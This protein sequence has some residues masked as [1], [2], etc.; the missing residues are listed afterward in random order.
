MADRAAPSGPCACR[1]DCVVD[2]AGGTVGRGRAEHACRR[3]GREPESDNDSDP[4]HRARSD[5]DSDSNS[6]AAGRADID[7]NADSCA[8]DAYAGPADTDAGAANTDSSAA[9]PHAN[10]GTYQDAADSYSGAANAHAD[11]PTAG[12]VR[13]GRPNG[14][15][16]ALL[17][18]G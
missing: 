3:H 12:V 8:S 9:H 10:P 6:D 4:G 14:R 18:A 1:S 17:P 11:P 16:A 15:G 5:S 7:A 2:D 13:R